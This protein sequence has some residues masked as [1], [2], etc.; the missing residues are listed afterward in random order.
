M[1]KKEYL[2][3]YS[4]NCLKCRHLCPDATKKYSKCHHTNGNPDC[5]AS[6]I[7]MVVVGRAYR[8][9]ASVI[10][11]RRKRDASLEAEV[12]VEV[13]NGSKAFQDRFY[14]RLSELQHAANKASSNKG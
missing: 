7:Q 12:M 14:S 13:S 10:Q 11:A 2:A 3:L 4:T 8:L 1:A 9:A 6:E 5:P